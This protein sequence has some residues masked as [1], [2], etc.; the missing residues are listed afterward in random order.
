LTALEALH[1]KQLVMTEALP[2]ALF[3]GS[4][5]HHQRAAVTQE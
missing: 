5:V 3:V 4:G 2:T 1:V